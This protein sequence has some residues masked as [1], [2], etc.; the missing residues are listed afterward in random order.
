MD[1]FPI[2]FGLWIL[3]VLL[4]VIRKICIS[5][6]R[7][8]RRS[9][10]LARVR[11]SDSQVS[12]TPEER[13]REIEQTL[14]TRKVVSRSTDTSDDDWWRTFRMVAR[15]IHF[16]EHASPSAPTLVEE[17]T[18]TDHE[19]HFDVEEGRHA[20]EEKESHEGPESRADGSQS[21]LQASTVFQT[22]S[23]SIRSLTEPSQPTSCDICLA[24]YE[25]DEEVSWSPNEDCTHA[26]HK[27]CITDWLMT[28]S[29]CPC[30]RRNYLTDGPV[31][32]DSN[33]ISNTAIANSEAPNATTVAGIA[34]S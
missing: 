29:T 10:Y 24:E 30:C 18:S 33:S 14:I 3:F 4:V 7:S 23:T 32:E 2:T 9:E 12:V 27:E 31:E 5:R 16:E 26:F 13:R 25:V 11:M 28:H 15:P 34:H 21:D 22:I 6:R 19:G 1:N 17:D 8:E 20:K